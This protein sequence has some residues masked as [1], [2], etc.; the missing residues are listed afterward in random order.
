MHE[1]ARWCVD[2]AR[3]LVTSGDQNDLRYA[4]LELRGAIEHLFYELIPLFADE[5]PSDIVYEWRPVQI[6]DAIVDCDPSAEAD[7]RIC[8][9]NY[10]SDGNP[11]QPHFL[12]EQKA[13]TR[14]LLRDYYHALGSYLH[15]PLPG[16]S[17]NFARLPKRLKATIEVLEEH[18]ASS[19]MANI[20]KKCSFECT[21]GRRITR[22]ARA[23]AANPIVKCLDS[24]CGAVFEYIGEDNEIASF[25]PVVSKF[26]CPECQTENC[27]GSHLLRDGLVVDCVECEAKVM[28]E[29][30]YRVVPLAEGCGVSSS[31]GRA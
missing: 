21:C 4:C 8:I 6:I 18:C 29:Q 7:S 9:F 5:L 11:G 1:E 31:S 28:Y 14:K 20:G 13:L 22:N 16:K 15:A 17:P 19:V 30:G 12:G 10:D 2:K 26:I 25:R 27:V 24:K 3:A 23:I